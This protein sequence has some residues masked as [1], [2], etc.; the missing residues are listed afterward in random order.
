MRA[1][2]MAAATTGLSLGC[3]AHNVSMDPNER[4]VPIVEFDPSNRVVPRWT[5]LLMD[6][7]D[8]FVNLPVSCMETPMLK[9]IR[10][11]LNLLDGFGSYEPELMAMVSHEVDEESLAGRVH[12]FCRDDTPTP[13]LPYQTLTPCHS[14]SDSCLMRVE[15]VFEPT[16]DCYGYH[17]NHRI[18]VT[19][20]KPLGDNRACGV[21]ITNGVLTD[22]AESFGPSPTWY[23]IRQAENPV[24][25][26]GN[27]VVRNL[28]PLDSG[29][30]EKLKD[31][32]KLWN[33]Y[34]P[35]LEFLE[36]PP[37]NLAR[38]QMLLAWEFT[39]QSTRSVFDPAVAG[40]PAAFLE[41]YDSTVADPGLIDGLSLT[42]WNDALDANEVEQQPIWQ[43]IN[44]VFDI[45]TLAGDK[46][47]CS[48]PQYSLSG[49]Q[50]CQSVSAIVEGQFWAPNFQTD[51]DNPGGL[52]EPVP[53]EWIPPLSPEL[54]RDTLLEFVAFVPHADPVP[55]RGFPVV[56]IGVGTWGT[57]EGLISQL[58]PLFAQNGILTIAIDWVNHGHR[59]VKT[60]GA[61]DCV[62]ADYK[63]S[64]FNCFHD[65]IGGDFAASRDNLR[66]TVLDLHR[67]VDVLQGC[68]PNRGTW[69]D[70]GC[71]P[72]RVDTEALG[73]FGH[74]IGATIGATFA[75]TVPEVRATVLRAGYAGVT[76]FILDGPPG[77][78][79][80][81]AANVLIAMGVID[82]KRW[83]SNDL[84][85]D[86]LCY[87]DEWLDDPFVQYIRSIAQWFF[88]GFDPANFG[89]F[90]AKQ[91]NSRTQHVLIQEIENDS[92]VA[93]PV[94]DK[95]AEVI[96][97]AESEIAS[98]AGDEGENGYFPNPTPLAVSGN[99]GWLLY[100]TTP[101]D[102]SSSPRFPGN[103]FQHTGNYFAAP[104]L[105][106]AARQL[107][108]DAV[109]FLATHLLPPP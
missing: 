10:E 24:K 9:D 102:D 103:T 51:V 32:E 60:S 85:M 79:R 59:A 89:A 41:G 101:P 47:I 93:N 16:A 13:D 43:W 66:Q 31:F 88:D 15:T 19:P 26:D 30:I 94:T 83:S 56:I 100:R 17:H 8:E 48:Y 97:F 92:V 57:K 39:T 38:D 91:V 63:D 98:S 11:S 61:D 53:G 2:I 44:D 76:D 50:G 20:T 21:V 52:D 75:S 71:G 106:Y 64:G 34:E 22:S 18:V 46:S 81:V 62:N 65:I 69:S 35:L 1:L 42:T 104:D 4:S 73:Y 3:S 107:Q 80:C 28:T 27:R 67:L 40:S 108:T 58:G 82:G 6:E 33:D 45:D 29:N 23:L 7:R 55:S 95:L 36:S 84:T 86:A 49:A 68:D 12:F 77:R 70:A 54:Q 72:I 105:M 14:D 37:H 74:S 96:G 25:L 78:F 90:L 99:S 5:S 109:S 87:E